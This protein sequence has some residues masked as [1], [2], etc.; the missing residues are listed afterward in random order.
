MR[1]FS[2]SYFQLIKTIFIIKWLNRFNSIKI[3]FF[4]YVVII[5]K[6]THTL[7]HK[8][9]KNLTLGFVIIFVFT[10]IKKNSLR[11]CKKFNNLRLKFELR[12]K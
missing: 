12:N 9:D 2:Q 5:S 11:Y 10:Q 3:T 1:H 8:L 6:K 7:Q 4:C